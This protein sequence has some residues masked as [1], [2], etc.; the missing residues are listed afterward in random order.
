MDMLCARL[1]QHVAEVAER[2]N[3]QRWLGVARAHMLQPP[4]VREERNVSRSVGAAAHYG[5]VVEDQDVVGCNAQICGMM[6]QR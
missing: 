6:H 4:I 1:H 5:V 2:R 3:R